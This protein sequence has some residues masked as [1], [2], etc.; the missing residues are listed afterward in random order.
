MTVKEKRFD[1]FVAANRWRKFAAHADLRGAPFT[2]ISRQRS[3]AASSP[4]A[5]DSLLPR[6]KKSSQPHFNRI[7]RRH[8]PILPGYWVANTTLA[9]SASSARSPRAGNNK[10][11]RSATGRIRSGELGATPKAFGAG[12]PSFLVRALDFHV[13]ERFEHVVERRKIFAIAC[14]ISCREHDVGNCLG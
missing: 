11:R 7:V 5:A 14:F 10:E 9:H 4:S 13:S 3:S 2:T 1:V 6:R 12:K 8:S